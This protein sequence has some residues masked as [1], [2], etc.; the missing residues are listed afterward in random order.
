MA[1]TILV[2]IRINLKFT[3]NKRMTDTF[4]L[5]LKCVLF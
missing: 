4:N 3:V 5:E 2:T 1:S